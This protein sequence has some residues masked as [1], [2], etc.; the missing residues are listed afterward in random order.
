MKKLLS[1]LAFTAILFYSCNQVDNGEI[2]SGNGG[3]IIAGGGD[4]GEGDENYN[5]DGFEKYT[6]DEMQ[7]PA[8]PY[9]DHYID[10]SK[11]YAVTTKGEK[12]PLMELED[13]I[14]SNGRYY[15]GFSAKKGGD[16]P[17]VYVDDYETIV[18]QMQ[19]YSP[20][21]RV[22]YP[23]EG[24]VVINDL[25]GSSLENI[26]DNLNQGNLKVSADG[27]T[28]TFDMNSILH[29][30]TTDSSLKNFGRS[31]CEFWLIEDH[32]SGYNPAYTSLV[33]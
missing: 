8:I 5:E 13:G 25:N 4:E 19:S 21:S 27:L 7:Q 1:L 32:P 6:G 20:I 33:I 23:K 11:S 31:L 14:L 28:V 18:V 15:T 2:D 24:D 22:C 9:L 26:N 10:F 17:I 16:S 12:V 30:N 3:I 29:N